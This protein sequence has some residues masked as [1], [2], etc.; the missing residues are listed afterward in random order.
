M[1]IVLGMAA[2][3]A[4]GFSLSGCLAVDAVSTVAGAATT[5]AG[6]AVD[7]GA[8]AVSGAASTVSGSSS[9]DDKDSGN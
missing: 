8:S 9:D 7:V 1:R 6:T 2:V 3:V 4:L 5:V